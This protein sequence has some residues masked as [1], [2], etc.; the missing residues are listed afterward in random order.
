MTHVDPVCGMTI[1]EADAVGTHQH[2]G[3]TY[4]FCS[5]EHK[6]EF[7]RNPVA[8]GEHGA[9]EPTLPGLGDRSAAVVASANAARPVTPPSSPPRALAADPVRPTHEP[10]AD[11]A[12]EWV[13][14]LE[15]EPSPPRAWPKLIGLTLLVMLTAMALGIVFARR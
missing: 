7:A 8:F 1:E 10:T 14:E 5:P 4:Y 12:A 13:D 11:A 2:G 15:G 9:R 3:V 6:G